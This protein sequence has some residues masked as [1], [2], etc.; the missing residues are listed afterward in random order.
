MEKILSYLDHKQKEL[1]N[2][3][4]DEDVPVNSAGAGAIAGLGVG[5][6]G[7]PGL[8]KK[9]AIKKVTVGRKLLLMPEEI[10]MNDFDMKTGMFAGN[11]TFIVP[12][13]MFD[14]A[15]LS[16]KKGQHWRTYIGNDTPHGQFIRNYANKN[17]KSPI[18][19]ECERTG[20]ITFAKYGPSK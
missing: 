5:P 10:D 16:K 1:E 15:R 18:P 13:T 14:K 11:K 8:K 12:S 7:E 9:P 17:P 4:L 6:K 19:L 3:F 2:P 20:Y